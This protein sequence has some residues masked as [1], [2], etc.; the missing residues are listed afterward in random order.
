MNNFIKN[1]LLISLAIFSFS[2]NSCSDQ[3]FNNLLLQTQESGISPKLDLSGT[4][5]IQNFTR[6]DATGWTTRTKYRIEELLTEE[7]NTNYLSKNKY[8]KGNLTAKINYEGG[9]TGGSFFQS[10]MTGFTLG[11]LNVFG[12]P[13]GTYR[14]NLNATFEITANNGERIWKKNYS[15]SK[16]YGFGLYKKNYGPNSVDNNSLNLFRKILSNFNND[17]SKNISSISDQ[18]SKNL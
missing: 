18:L 10:F 5:E 6:G 13:V 11:I 16:S 1:L 14:L 9:L 12:M 17:L 3:V 4:Y 7:I 8:K 15:E 2:F